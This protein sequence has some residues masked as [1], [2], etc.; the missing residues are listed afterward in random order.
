MKGREV[1]VGSLDPIPLDREAWRGRAFAPE[2]QA[3]LGEGRAQEVWRDY[4]LT[5]RPAG[6]REVSDLNYDLF[7]RDEFNTR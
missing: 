6:E 7:P 5:A 2:V 3:Y 1:L 4:L